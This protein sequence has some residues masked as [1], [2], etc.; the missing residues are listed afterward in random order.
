[1]ACVIIESIWPNHSVSQRTQLCSLRCFVAETHRQ[2]R[3]GVDALELC[4]FYLLRAKSIIQA[5]QRAA[6]Q[7]EEAEEEQRKQQIEQIEKQSQMSF[8]SILEA[9][10][11]TPPLSPSS[12]MSLSRASTNNVIVTKSSSAHNANSILSP[13]SSSPITPNSTQQAIAQAPF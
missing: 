2:S 6:R 8:Q 1:I 5:R 10:Q 12:P 9:T 4:M 13:P 11:N 3:L 7:K